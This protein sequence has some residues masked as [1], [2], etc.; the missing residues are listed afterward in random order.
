M[1]NV[2]CI[3]GENNAIG[4]NN[5]LIWNIPD[6]LKHFKKITENHPVIMGRKTFESIGKSLPNRVNIIITRDKNY[7]AEGC[8]ICNS[9]DEAIQISRDALQCVSTISAPP[10]IFVI[11]GGEIY[12]QAIPCADKLYLTIVEDSPKDADTFFPDYTEFKN[13]LSEE[14]HE[15]NGLKYKFVELGR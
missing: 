8:H 15:Y 3:L 14:K 6:D 2:I 12:R 13:I 4:K 1:I 11:G 7:K 10:E 9:L 5:K